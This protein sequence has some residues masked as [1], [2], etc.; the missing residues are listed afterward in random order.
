MS[1]GP[2]HLVVS[3]GSLTSADAL[4]LI[5][6]LDAELTG[7]YPNPGDN[8]FALTA[9]EV[10]E[11]L[12]VFLVARMGRGRVG[13][14]AL[15]RLDSTTG[16]IK[17]MFVVP[18]ARGMGAGRRL[19]TELERHARGLGLRRLVLETGERQPEA[20]GLYESA[21]FVR[22]PC[23]GDYAVSPASVCMEKALD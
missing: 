8:H 3:P 19:L 7:R 11:G 10:S 12:G 6:L 21:G 23:F 5:A 1:D 4:A 20:N 14:G 22:I 16:E 2:G 13:C 17:R 9:A 15:R 18:A